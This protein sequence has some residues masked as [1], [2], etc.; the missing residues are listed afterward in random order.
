[1]EKIIFRIRKSKLK[2][3]IDKYIED[4]AK[5]NC[6]FESD[7]SFKRYGKKITFAITR[8]DYKNYILIRSWYVDG[9][10][11]GMS[12]GEYYYP[13]ELD[14]FCKNMEAVMKGKY[15]CSECRKIVGSYKELNYRLFASMLCEECEK[16]VP[17]VDYGAL[18]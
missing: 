18:D 17:K 6:G 16:S 5:R 11:K 13:S 3:Q 8:N 12:A 9:K 10:A 1:M 4:M 7:V 15:I 14:L 2:K